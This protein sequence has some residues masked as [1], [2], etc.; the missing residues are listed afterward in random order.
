MPTYI[1]SNKYAR[2]RFSFRHSGSFSSSLDN[3]T[4]FVS[5]RIIN[6]Q[7]PTHDTENG[8]FPFQ[9]FFIS[10][11]SNRFRQTIAQWIFILVIL[12]IWILL[13]NGHAKLD[14]S[15]RTNDMRHTWSI[16][17]AADTAFP[18]KENKFNLSQA[19]V[20]STRALFTD[21]YSGDLC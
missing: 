15:I 3:P 5:E 10:G 8:F 6:H 9:R 18:C 17:A 4:I 20:F 16:P 2:V 19:L 11:W 7:K 13:D 21:I 14:C 12:M 1:W